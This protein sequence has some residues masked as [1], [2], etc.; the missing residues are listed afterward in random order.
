MYHS[1]SNN[2]CIIIQ[3]L[4]IQNTDLL[5]RCHELED[6]YRKVL[7]FKTVM[8]S[9]EE[10]VQQLAANNRELSDEKARFE[11][12][13]RKMSETCAYLEQDR[14]RNVEQVQLLEEQIKEME[15]GGGMYLLF[16]QR[17]MNAY[18]SCVGTIME[19][20]INNSDPSI[21]LED[22]DMDDANNMEENMKK[23]NVTEL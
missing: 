23:A 11:E 15:L 20:A 12:E 10:Q 13:L 16:I 6:E 2:K 21:H 7:R 1:L 14:D 9:F 4:E 5:K 17:C 19:K 8:G 22:E 3:A 18:H